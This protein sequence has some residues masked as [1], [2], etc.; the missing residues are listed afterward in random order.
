MNRLTP[1]CV[2]QIYLD[3]SSGFFNWFCVNKVQIIK[4]TMLQPI[5]EQAGVLHRSSQQMPVKL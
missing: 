5:W 3:I 2:K 1:C 4:S